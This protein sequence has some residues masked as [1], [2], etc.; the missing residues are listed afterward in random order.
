M[1]TEKADTYKS[2]DQ[3]YAGKSVFVTGGT[4]FLGKVF[5]EKLL[6][7]CPNIDKIYVLMREKNKWDISERIKQMLELPM[8]QRLKRERPEDLKKII[9][10]PGNVTLPNL[11][12][13]EE[14]KKVLIKKVSHVFHFAANIKFNEPLKVAVN[15][16][17]EGTRRVLNL[18]HLMK[19]IEV[20]VYVSTAFSNTDQT[21]L[22]EVVYPPPA[23]VEEVKRLIEDDLNEEQS[24]KLLC[25]RPNTYTFAKALAESVVNEEHGNIPTIIVRPSIVS[26]SV[27]DPVMGWVDN[28]FG[29]TA[30]MTTIAKGLNRIIISK[31][32]NVIDL[33]PVDYVS[34]LTVAAGVKSNKSKEVIVYNCC[35][36]AENPLTM[37]ELSGLI[38]EDS[39]KNNFSEIM[40]PSL[41]FT[42][43]EWLLKIITL[44]MQTIP[45]FVADCW[46]R[47]AGKPPRF[48]KMQNRISLVRDT[49]Q[50]FTSRS[51]EMKCDRTRDLFA[52]LSVN[53]RLE[54]PFDPALITW[55]K[56][57]PIYFI[58]IRKFMYKQ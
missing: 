50:Y 38:T 25:G 27:S 43:F 56:Y 33:I 53:D 34:N 19:N 48:M 1:A 4:G 42:Q 57:I 20:F 37:G 29:A 46:L 40:K 8:F 58:G 13:S 3:L 9:A 45:A 23:T 55:S 32:S 51:W 14:N 2:I 49:L 36:S 24:K 21:V 31:S 47:L 52:S 35:T 39:V 6:Y 17:V 41:I 15:D 12:I 18:C 28:W 22:E 54:F 7:S 11:G 5:L 44:F 26:A 10:I 16:N 30:L